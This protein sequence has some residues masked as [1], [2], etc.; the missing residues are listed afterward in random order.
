MKHIVI[1]FCLILLFAACGGEETPAV[2]GD[3]IIVTDGETEKAYTAEDLAALGASQAVFA[4][5]T[6]VG[7]PLAALLAD[8]GFDPD[9]LAAVKATAD[10]GFSANYEPE[11]VNLPDAIV[12]YAT[13]E[14]ELSEDDGNFRMVLPGQEGKL[15]PRHLVTILVY[16]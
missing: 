7:V 6:Y 14:G 3:V 8:A 9:N 2:S 16:P 12:A 10:D 13:V 5:V 15:N 4:E 1:L 11:L